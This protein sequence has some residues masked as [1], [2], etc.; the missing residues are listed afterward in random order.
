MR[1]LFLPC[2][3]WLAALPVNAQQAS[4]PDT[5]DFSVQTQSTGIN[6]TNK[7]PK[8][9]NFG[10]ALLKAA[11][12]CSPYSENLVDT[13]PDWKKYARIFGTTAGAVNVTIEGKNNNGQC[14][15]SVENALIGLQ[16]LRYDCAISP[17]EQQE[18]YAAMTDPSSTPVTETFTTYIT[19]EL[20]DGK[21]EKIPTQMTMTDLKFNIVWNKLMANACTKQTEEPSEKA[22]DQIKD[23]M[24]SF[25]PQFIDNLKKCLPSKE[26]KQFLF[27]SFDVEIKGM[28]GDQC[29]IDIDPFE[30]YP[31][32][33]ELA[34]LTTLEKVFTF[35]ETKG[36]DQVKYMPQ[37]PSDGI[38]L[39]LEA[40][41]K[42]TLRYEGVK[43]SQS[44]GNIK[45][46]KGIQSSFKDGI[47]QIKLANVI[48][49]NGQ[50]KGYGKICQIPQN[51]IS[52]FV[53]SSDNFVKSSDNENEAVF[54]MDSQQDEETL[55]K[56]LQSQW[57]Q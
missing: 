21:T 25:S 13:N 50:K 35:A 43:S 55:K 30:L 24:L 2:L 4:N 52:A 47:C 32:Q 16:T 45:I 33:S 23:Q 41:R 53:K 54:S 31:N 57:C 44:F 22:L 48:E 7:A 14:L 46:R 17:Q 8:K 39:A 3:C 6:V 19:M 26:T 40:C 28:K 27:L 42:G 10:E 1:K 38:T 56:L 11:K 49:R 20:P 9:I 15:F 29:Q 12:D 34:D 36:D 37:Y 5:I 18:L 51:E